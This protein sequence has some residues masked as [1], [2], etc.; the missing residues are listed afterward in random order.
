V[1]ETRR[2]YAALYYPYATFGDERWLA[3]SLLSWDR[4]ALIRPQ[5]A[6]ASLA[7][8]GPVERAIL[9]HP[10]QDFINPVTPDDESLERVYEAFEAADREAVDALRE[11]YGPDARGGLASPARPT[12]QAAP[13]AADPRLIWIFAAD[14]ESKMSY[15]MAE[16]LLMSGLAVES[17]DSDH[18]RWLGLH[19]QL[20]A[21]YLTALSGEL[22]RTRGYVACT[23][24]LAAHRAAGAMDLDQ[25]DR[26]LYGRRPRAGIAPTVQ[27]VEARYLHIALRAGLHPVNVAE[28]PVETL[29]SF[30]DQ[31]Q[32]E[33]RAFRDHLASI[34]RELVAMTG[35]ADADELARALQEV[36]DTR[37]RE[38]VD[39][40]RTAMRRSGIQTALR[41]LTLKLDVTGAG[42]TLPGL[43]AGA[44]ATALGAPVVAG[45]APVA[46]ALTATPLIA[47][48]RRAR[49][50]QQ[51]SPFAFLIAAEHALGADAA[52]RETLPQ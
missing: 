52:L 16:L 3:E 6:E 37:T 28:V 5:G 27:Q 43:A 36:Y 21:V 22:A 13:A 19:P 30:R 48:Y 7:S 38:Q 2:P 11:R 50:R 1:I 45:L 12:R 18:Q 17:V 14:R 44:A 20:A 8:A 42:L 33:I 51:D 31:H 47:G 24:D 15:G 46:L 25:I 23:D 40:L 39:D 32:R 49:H 26:T 4:V 34:E 35:I 9:A 10:G 41:A 29:L